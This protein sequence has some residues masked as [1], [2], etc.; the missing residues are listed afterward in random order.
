[1]YISHRVYVISVVLPHK[2]EIKMRAVFYAASL[3]CRSCDRWDAYDTYD[4]ETRADFQA[5][6]HDT[7]KKKLR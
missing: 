1:M 3:S 7:I 5:T 6:T 4:Q 2:K